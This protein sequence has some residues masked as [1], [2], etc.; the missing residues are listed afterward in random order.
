MPMTFNQLYLLIA[1]GFLLISC[2]G[3]KASFVLESS[4]STVPSRLTLKELNTGK[5]SNTWLLNGKNINS[6]ASSPSIL[7][8]KSGS[9]DVTLVKESKGKMDSMTQSITIDPPKTNCLVEI[10]TSM[11]TMVAALSDLCLGH[12][13]HFE[14]MILD[15]FYDSLVFHRVIPNFVVQGGDGKTAKKGFRRIK[16]DLREDIDSEFHYELLHYRGALAMAR[17]PDQMNPDKKSSPDQ[18]YLVVG[19]P[20]NELS[21]DQFEQENGQEYTSYQKERYY[22]QGGSPQLDGQY[23]VFGYVIEGFNVLDEISKVITDEKDNPLEKIYMEL[24]IIE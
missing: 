15:A 5:G 6:R 19:S 9:Y 20:L 22:K 21:L 18:F 1:F 17:M 14:N 16:K 8:T 3:P 10:K 12:S 11:G 13:D 4:N 2:G 7:I 24:S 23:T